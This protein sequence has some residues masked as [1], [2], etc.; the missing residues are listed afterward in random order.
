MDVLFATPHKKKAGEKDAEA[1]Q[2]G[3]RHIWS[4]K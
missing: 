2:P 1:G 4:R 3:A